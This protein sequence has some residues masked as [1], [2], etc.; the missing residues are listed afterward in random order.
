LELKAELVSYTREGSQW[1]GSIFVIVTVSDRA[2]ERPGTGL[3]VCTQKEGRE[4]GGARKCTCRTVERISVLILVV[5]VSTLTAELA[6]RAGNILSA[7]H[8]GAW[9]VTGAEWQQLKFIT[10]REAA[11]GLSDDSSVCKITSIRAIRHIQRNPLRYIVFITV[12]NPL[13]TPFSVCDA[14]AAVDCA[15]GEVRLSQ[16]SSSSM[17]RSSASSASAS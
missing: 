1:K 16:S 4:E 14:T 11:G 5:I 3:L 2:S 10:P 13:C 17:A 15:P 6:G 8:P 12:I 7:R 9:S